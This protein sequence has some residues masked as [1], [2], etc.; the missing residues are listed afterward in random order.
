MSII[1]CIAFHDMKYI[2]QTE[3]SATEVHCV[4]CVAYGTCVKLKLSVVMKP[5]NRMR[6]STLNALPSHDLTRLLSASC[7]GMSGVV[8][9]V[10]M[11]ATIA[12]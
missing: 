9:S 1:V 7:L 4:A 3:L 11:I 6:F 2:E 5:A 12:D 8:S 10:V